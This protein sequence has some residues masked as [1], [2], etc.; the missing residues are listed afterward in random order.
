MLQRIKS[1]INKKDI[2]A[3]VGSCGEIYKESSLNKFKPSV[4][5]KNTKEL[6]NTGI[7]LLCD[8][9]ISSEKAETEINIIKNILRKY[10]V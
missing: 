8:P 10:C 9:T 6:F 7:M 5:L 2:V 3:T 4:D 1:D